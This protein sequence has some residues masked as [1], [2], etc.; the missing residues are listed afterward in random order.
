MGKPT[1]RSE[2]AD[3]GPRLSAMQTDFR[4]T[5]AIAA[6]STSLGQPAPVVGCV[7]MDVITIDVTDLP[8]EFGCTL[9]QAVDITGPHQPISELARRAGMLSDEFLSRL[10]HRCGEFT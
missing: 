6:L 10:G 4:V 8:P 5:S 9:V 7:S 2:R 1:E 3:R